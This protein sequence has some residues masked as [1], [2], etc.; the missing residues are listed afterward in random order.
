MI[1]RILRAFKK[2]L[3]LGMV[4]I[5]GYVAFM[6]YVA[7]ETTAVTSNADD[8][9]WAAEHAPTTTTTRKTLTSG[10]TIPTTTKPD[11]FIVIFGSKVVHVTRSPLTAQL[12]TLLDRI[13]S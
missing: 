10:P 9:I 6:A 12:F 2:L 11:D 13:T 1:D 5:V 8:L 7:P 4:L 3:I